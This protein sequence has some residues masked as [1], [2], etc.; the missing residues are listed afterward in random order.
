LILQSHLQAGVSIGRA[1]KKKK[2]ANVLFGSS[3]LLMAPERQADFL[4]TKN[5][6]PSLLT[7]VT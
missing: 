6:K 7:S 3:I 4:C 1:Q 2:K 5:S